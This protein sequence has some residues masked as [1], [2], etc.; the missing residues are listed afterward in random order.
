MSRVPFNFL[1]KCIELKKKV[2]TL[3]GQNTNFDKDEQKRIYDWYSCVLFNIYKESKTLLHGKQ[4]FTEDPQSQWLNQFIT[5]LESK[6]IS[7][8]FLKELRKEGNLRNKLSNMMKDSIPKIPVRIDPFYWSMRTAIRR[9]VQE[10]SEKVFKLKFAISSTGVN[11]S[12]NTLEPYNA[13][14]KEEIQKEFP[15]SFSSQQILQLQANP[16]TY[17]Q[18]YKKSLQKLKELPLFGGEHK[19]GQSTV[20]YDSSK[21]KLLLDMLANAKAGTLNPN[22]NYVLKKQKAVLDVFHKH[23]NLVRNHEEVISALKTLEQHPGTTPDVKTKIQQI[24][25]DLEAP[26]KRLVTMISIFLILVCL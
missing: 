26:S 7:N 11:P 23:L 24:F 21:I 22:S 16:H 4:L 14:Q 9:I 13:P 5:T 20:L 1:E 8:N 17:Y 12:N 15:S 19:I 25:Q 18:D 2:K 3:I 10:C 6:I